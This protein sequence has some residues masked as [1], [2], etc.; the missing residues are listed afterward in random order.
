MLALLP[1]YAGLTDPVAE[2]RAACRAAVAWLVEAGP[3][4]VLGD[5]Q[6]RGVGEHLLA[7]AGPTRAIAAE[8]QVPAARTRSSAAIAPE[9]PAAAVL[10]VGNGSACRSEKAPGFLDERSFGFDESLRVAL[11]R[12]DP[13]ALAGLDVAQGRELLAATD[14][15]RALGELLTPQHT[16]T[17]D[18]DDDPFG[19][20]YWV[21][22][23]DLPQPARR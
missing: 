12:P 6:G 9:Q 13:H 19:V 8:L 7:E 3:V 20:Q 22:R 2:L 15:L 5:E 4:T 18:Y 21:V 11:T 1:E 17:V 16:A 23:W 10:A 14:G